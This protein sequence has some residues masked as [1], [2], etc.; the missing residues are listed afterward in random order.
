MYHLMSTPLEQHHQ[1]HTVIALNPVY[2]VRK[3]SNNNI[4]MAQYEGV[5]GRLKILLDAER[6]PRVV[7]WSFQE[8]FFN[9]D[10]L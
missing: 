3:T 2:I 6:F 10:V 4:I 8:I 5:S 9:Y 7:V 1:Q